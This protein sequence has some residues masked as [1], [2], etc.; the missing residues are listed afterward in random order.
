M[1]KLAFLG[2]GVLWIAVG[3]FF[4]V[5]TKHFV[6]KSRKATGTVVGLK[7]IWTSSTSKSTT[8]RRPVYR[9]VIEFQTAEG[10]RI[11][12]TSSHGSN[13]PTYRKGDRVEVLYD[14]KNPQESRLLSFGSLW[15]FPVMSIGIGSLL[16][17]IGLGIWMWQRGSGKRMEWFKRNGVPIMAEIERI[18]VNKKVTL[19]GKHPYKIYARHLNPRTKQT[20]I[21]KSRNIWEDPTEYFSAHNIKEIEVWVTPQDY[22]KYLMNT[23]FIT[24]SVGTTISE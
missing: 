14:P 5:E 17:L 21:F 8:G 6:S 10:R 15:L 18:S 19:N 11:Q 9:P 2:F 3:A 22:S 7:K 4:S 20:Q 24:S 23:D 12:F 16:V 13:P 1:I